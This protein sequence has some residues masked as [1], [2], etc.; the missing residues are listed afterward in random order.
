MMSKK[1]LYFHLKS[2]DF[3]IKKSKYIPSK[4]SNFI[5]FQYSNK[6]SLDKSSHKKYI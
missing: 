1:L 5:Q 6:Y 3:I 2:P 4:R